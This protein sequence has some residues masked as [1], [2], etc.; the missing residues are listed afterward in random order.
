MPEPGWYEDPLGSGRLRLWTGTTWTEQLKDRGGEP[1]AGSKPPVQGDRLAEA[2]LQI[3]RTEGNP[4]EVL[5]QI[6]SAAFVPLDLIVAAGVLMALLGVRLPWVRVGLTPL[7]FDRYGTA[8]DGTWIVTLTAFA[9][10]LLVMG[11][12][13]PLAGRVVR[14]AG[15]AASGATIALVA[16][17]DLWAAQAGAVRITRVSARVP[18]VAQPGLYVTIAAG[19]AIF[20][21]GTAGIVASLRPKASV[22]RG[23]GI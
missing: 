3:G 8:V 20:V 9:I 14:W 19:L 15:L 18:S 5:D 17:V 16:L 23:G 22:G 7:R 13:R 4:T 11:Y 2:D 6:R 21:G 12:F 10:V 1:S